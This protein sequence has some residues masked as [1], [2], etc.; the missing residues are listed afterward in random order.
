[1]NINKYNREQKLN[2]SNYSK[3]HN[4]E[5]IRYQYNIGYIYEKTIYVKNMNLIYYT[6]LECR[7]QLS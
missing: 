6:T 2:K 3:L 1:M 5:A 4:N 7:L